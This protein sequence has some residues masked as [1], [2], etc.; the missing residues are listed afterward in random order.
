M[1]LSLELW[2]YQVDSPLVAAIIVPTA[3]LGRGD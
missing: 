2:N 1:N 3:I